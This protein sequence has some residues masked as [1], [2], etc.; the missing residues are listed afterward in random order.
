MSLCHC[1]GIVTKRLFVKFNIMN[2]NQI[3]NLKEHWNVSSYEDDGDDCG[4]CIG[5]FSK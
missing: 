4:C 2:T 5:G 3:V 1:D